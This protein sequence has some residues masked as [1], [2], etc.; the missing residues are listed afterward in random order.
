MFKSIVA[1]VTALISLICSC[2]SG[3][4]DAVIYP[5]SPQTESVEFARNLG[6]GWNLGNTLD[7]CAKGSEEKKGLESEIYWGNPYTTGEMIEYIKAAGFKSVRIPITWAQHL[8]ADGKID[9]AWLDR[10]NEIVDWVID[11]G[12]YAIINVHH[13]DAFW[14]ITDKAHEESAKNMLVKIWAQV[15][16]RFRDYDERLIFET[17]NEPRVTGI[18]TEWSGTDEH[19]RVVNTLN[20]AALETIRSSGGN[21]KNRFVM[22]PSYA[23]S[24]TQENIEALALPDDSRVMISLHFYYATAH[25]SEYP[26]CAEKLTIGD[27]REIYHTFR[28]IHKAFIA[29]G[30][31]VV[32]S[33][34]GWT[35]RANLENLAEKAE[36]YVE[37]A[38]KFS[39]PCMVWN[40]GG[41]FRLLDRHSLQWEFPAYADA[42][43]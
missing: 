42:I 4:V 10:V 21:N 12:M 19:R 18:D 31:G 29:K 27:K 28:R 33:E 22:I 9:E 16:E 13:D 8:D 36:F 40:N 2:F 5:D 7:A 15:S 24:S 17:M 23:A 30:Y 26:D 37:T 43:I 20:F 11:S 41:D 38:N 6:N 32:A 14:L 1:A 39:I 25:S 35:D 34:F 3:A